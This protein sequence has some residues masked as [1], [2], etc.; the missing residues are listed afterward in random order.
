MLAV[1]VACLAAAPAGAQD[2]AQAPRGAK[3]LALVLSGGGARGAAHIG[4]LKVLEEQH[5]VPDLIV[6]TSMGSIVGGLYAAGYSP[7]E[8]EAVLRSLD[9]D[10]VFFDRVDRADRSFRRKQDDTPYFIPFKLRFKDGKPYLPSGLFAGQ[11]LEFILRSLA[12]RAT[13]VENFDDL[14]IPF[15]A[16]AMDLS[17]AEAVVLGAGKLADAMRASMSI[18]GAFAPVVIDGRP[19]VDGGSAANLPVGIAQRLGADTVIAVDISSPLETDV[20]DRSFL[21]VLNQLTSFLTSGSVQAD[22]QLLRPG[23]VLIRPDLGDITFSSFDSATEAVAIGERTARSMAAELRPFAATPERWEEFRRTHV[24]HDT[25]ALPVSEVQ[26]DYT[27]WVDQRIVERRLEVPLG[28]PLDEAKLIGHLT[29]LRGLDY[30][31]MMRYDLEPAGDSTSLRIDIDKKHHGHT[32]LQA[33]ASL[34]TDFGGDSS[35]ALLFRHQWLALNRRGAEW[36]N[37]LQVGDRALLLSEFHQPLGWGLRWYVRPKVRS[38]QENL[39]IWLDGERV[40]EY[41]I[42][43]SEAALDVGRY[44][45]RWGDLHGSLF[46]GVDQGDPRIGISGLPSFDEDSGGVRLRFDV[47]TRDLPLFARHGT[48]LRTQ[49]ER[50]LDAFGATGD[51]T[52]ADLRWRLFLTAGRST[53]SPRVEARSNFSGDPSVSSAVFIGGFQRL[54]GLGDN[55]LIG[56]DGGVAGVDYWFELFGLEEG[57]LRSRVFAGASLEAGNAYIEGDPITWSSLRTGGALW[58][59]AATPLGPFY[60]GWGWTDPDRS[61]VYLIIGDRY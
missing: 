46:R 26:L 33:G 34:R 8:I 32:N 47:D 18:P 38:D 54:S 9:W 7:D 36:V 48:D 56:N 3:R 49:V 16:V 6:G 2:P 41:R 58:V 29:D 17:T 19:L 51:L 45:G 60:L 24:T 53:L 40:A 57:P 52:V 4:V 59:G 42:E 61:R 23:D 12:L 30:F 43:R 5:V 39:S 21:E 35:Y 50:D 55:E 15:R 20:R 27:G 31:G 28:Q 37:T 25:T 1:G 10:A 13:S 11:R 44:F 22:I 14:P